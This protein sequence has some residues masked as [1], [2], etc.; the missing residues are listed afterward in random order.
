MGRSTDEVEWVERWKV[1]E[2]FNRGRE[3]AGYERESFA[4]RE[5]ELAA[6]EAELRERA[7]AIGL[8]EYWTERLLDRPATRLVVVFDDIDRRTMPGVRELVEQGKRYLEAN[9]VRTS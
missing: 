9:D 8:A 6:A 3:S 7:V 1:E 4:R 2:A 5:R